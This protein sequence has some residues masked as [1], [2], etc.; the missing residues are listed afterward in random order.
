MS[1]ELE[2]MLS[3]LGAF[4]TGVMIA[5]EFKIVKKRQIRKEDFDEI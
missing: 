1:S 2:M 3:F 5:F 4:A